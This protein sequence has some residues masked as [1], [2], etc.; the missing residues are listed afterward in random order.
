M[1]LD[2]DGR[3][4][5]VSGAASGIGRATA[6]VLAGMGARLLVSDI[7]EDARAFA[8]LAE[9]QTVTFDEHLK[10]ETKT[11]TKCCS[12]LEHKL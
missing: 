5:L 2:L 7:A 11:I 3:V 1:D 9:G 10:R 12:C 8:E 4:A 6:G